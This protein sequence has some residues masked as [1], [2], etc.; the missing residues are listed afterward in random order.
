MKKV[1]PRLSKDMLKAAGEA[2]AQRH[3]G[4]L[5]NPNA[6]ESSAACQVLEKVPPR[7]EAA[8][9][10]SEGM[11]RV[12]EQRGGFPAVE[13]FVPQGSG[14]GP[15]QQRQRRPLSR[16]E[17]E[18]HQAV[19]EVECLPDPA[20][21]EDDREEEQVAALSAS[22]SSPSAAG[23]LG[24]SCGETFVVHDCEEVGEGNFVVPGPEEPSQGRDNSGKDLALRVGIG[25]RIESLH[26]TLED[27]IGEEKFISVYKYLRKIGGDQ[28]DADAE[29]QARLEGILGTQNIQ[30]AFLIHKLLMLEDSLY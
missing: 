12:E 9:R 10:G 5:L 26:V 24:G 21:A 28:G 11:S 6:S 15:T 13:I 3:R 2:F 4:Q 18:M 20:G 17:R 22:I 7:R 1:K 27:K 8:V 25:Q 30:Y 19:R 23:S 14:R 16:Q 29:T